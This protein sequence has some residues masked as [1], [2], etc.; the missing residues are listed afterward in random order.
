MHA[1]MR[2]ANIFQGAI[3][4]HKTMDGHPKNE[5]CPRKHQPRRRCQST[6]GICIMRWRL[7]MYVAMEA[8]AAPVIADKRWDIN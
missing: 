6:V 5:V 7:P 8:M 4:C 3:L 1:S 2:A